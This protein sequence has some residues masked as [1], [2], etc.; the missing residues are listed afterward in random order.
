IKC[1]EQVS[2]TGYQPLFD[3]QLTITITIL[4]YL[5]GWIYIENYRL[6][7]KTGQ[8]AIRSVLC[9]FSLMTWYQGYST[10]IRICRAIR[11]FL[12]P[13]PPGCVNKNSETGLWA[14]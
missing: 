10:K 14:I 5:W 12:K 7:T 2:Q 3:G 8:A 13:M 9:L 6:D 1:N 11:G 4:A